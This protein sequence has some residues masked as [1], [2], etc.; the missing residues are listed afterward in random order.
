MCLHCLHKPC[1]KHTERAL[2]LPSQLFHQRASNS[3]EISLLVP[4][5]RH[6]TFC[7]CEKN[8][9]CSKCGTVMISCS[10]RKPGCCK[11]YCPRG[12]SQ[13][14]LNQEMLNRFHSCII[15]NMLV[16]PVSINANL[17]RIST[18]VVWFGLF[19]KQLTYLFQTI[20]WKNKESSCLLMKGQ[21]LHKYCPPLINEVSWLG[22][23][24]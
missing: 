1:Q 6:E 14:S 9:R 22:G 12:D 2:S 7:P 11:N 15:S 16:L 3:A 4:E 24:S 20:L 19:C 10:K 18:K 23:C 17:L 21:I 5:A 8:Y 13:G